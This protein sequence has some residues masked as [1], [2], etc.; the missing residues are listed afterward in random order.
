MFAGWCRHTITNGRCLLTW[1]ARL[2]PPSDALSLSAWSPSLSGQH[3]SLSADFGF[4]VPLLFWPGRSL[5]AASATAGLRTGKRSDGLGHPASTD[6][7]CC[8]FLFLSELGIS[9]I[10][11]TNVTML[12]A[13]GGFC[14][15]L[16]SAGRTEPS[17]RGEPVTRTA[18]GRWTCAS[19][20]CG[21]KPAEGCQ[22]F[23]DRPQ[24]TNLLPVILSDK[25]TR[26]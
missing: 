22:N 6:R 26:T 21:T 10:D 15:L 17:Q 13:V 9:R 1:P 18:T 25:R 4:A 23:P 24:T 20:S 11:N 7:R 14:S 2:Y 12:P 3:P 16:Q 5:R 19:T 8:L